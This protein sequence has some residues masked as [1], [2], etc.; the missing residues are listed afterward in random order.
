M[1]Y[2]RVPYFLKQTR[3]YFSKGQFQVERY[4]LFPKDK[5]KF[6][7]GIVLFV[8]ENISEKIIVINFQLV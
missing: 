5:N 3:Q 4:R 8:K 7:G 6:C 2:R 1:K